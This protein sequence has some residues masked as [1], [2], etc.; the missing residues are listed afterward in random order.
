MA[1]IRT[2][3]LYA[4][5]IDTNGDGS[6]TIDILGDLTTVGGALDGSNGTSFYTECPAG[7]ILLV[8]GFSLTIGIDGKADQ[9]VY[10]TGGTGTALANG[11][12]IRLLSDTNAIEGTFTNGPSAHIKTLSDWC[13][14]LPKFDIFEI[15]TSKDVLIGNWDSNHSGIP[16]ILHE[17]DKFEVL[18]NDNFTLAAH[19]SI[20]KQRI[21]IQGAMYDNT[22]RNRNELLNRY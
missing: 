11:I 10:G 18:V 19:T 12:Q 20:I 2:G 6:G 7:K 14:Y 17:G 8:Q 21:Q 22:P 3:E 5:F 4:Q 9:E 15:G 1:H 13:T 16:I